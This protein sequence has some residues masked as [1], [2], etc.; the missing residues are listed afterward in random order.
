[1]KHFRWLTAL[2]MGAFLLAACGGMQAGVPEG[3]VALA[4]T[5]PKNISE[6]VTT[7]PEVSEVL[8]FGMVAIPAN[9]TE[10]VG[11]EY[12]VKLEGEVGEITVGSVKL[13]VS[14]NKA[15]GYTVESIGAVI[16]E[17][18]FA[19]GNNARKFT[20]D[21]GVT[22]ASPLP[23]PLNPTGGPGDISHT[24]FCYTPDDPFEPDGDVTVEKTALTSFTRTHDWSILKS[25]DPEVV[26]LFVD[27]SGDTKVVW[28]VDVTYEGFDDSDWMVYGEIKVTNFGNINARVDTITDTINIGELIDVTD[29]T[30]Y[31]SAGDELLAL[32]VTLIPG[33]FIRCTYEADLDA[34]TDGVNL[35]TADGVF[36]YPDTDVFGTFEEDS[37]EVGFTFDPDAEQPLVPPVITEVNKTAAVKDISDLFGDVDLGTVTAPN[38]DQFTYEEDF[39]YADYDECGDFTYDNTAQVIGDDDVVL[40]E[41]DASLLVRVQCLVFAG[42][43]AWAA[44][45]NTPLELRYTSRGNWA[46]YVAYAEKSTTL[47]AGQTVNVGSVSFSAVADGKITI[48]VNLTGDWEFE[49]VLEN[50]KVQDYASAPSGN[51]EPGL[52]DHKEDCDP[53]E[54]TCSITVPANN[55]YGVHVNVG[56]WGPDP[57]F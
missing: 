30:C 11:C 42:E 18:Y 29:I 20:F 36:L 54:S 40:D 25:V 41:D 49:D 31:D 33:D 32:G 35:A 47:F 4:T 9:T 3:E 27:G 52:F 2:V 19:I 56:E 34:A 48:T 24:F 55:Y 8:D 5:Y 37:G 46:T 7:V 43:T 16:D 51:P 44:N 53:G 17:V 57:N 50:L 39:A 13:E 28:T 26:K 12:V 21:P 10:I 38:G 45:G 22:Y 6:A 14:G 23:A 1:M 15:T